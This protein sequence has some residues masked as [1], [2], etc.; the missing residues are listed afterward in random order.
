LFGVLTASGRPGTADGAV[1]INVARS[2]AH[3]GTFEAW[4]CTPELNSNH[5]V[6]GVDGRYYAGFGLLPSALVVP[7]LLVAEAVAHRT[8]RDP[9]VLAAFAISLTTVAVGALVPALVALWLLRLGLPWTPS[10]AAALVVFFG[11]VLWYD[12]VK[13][14]YSEPYFA[15]GLL[16]TACLISTTSSPSGAFGA[17]AAFGVAIASR[18]VGIVFGPLLAVYGFA[19]HDGGTRGGRLQRMCVFGLGVAPFLIAIVAS[20]YV[21]F[22]DV[23]KT[24]YHLAYPTPAILFSTPLAD[25]L[26]RLL[27]DGEVGLLWFSPWVILLPWAWV[28]AWRRYRAECLLSMAMLAEGLFFFAKYKAWHGGWAFGPRMLTPC[29]PFAAPAL[30][31]LFAGLRDR[32][33]VM[34]AAVVTLVTVAVL[35]QLGGAIYPMARYYQLATYH[36]IR[37]EPAPF[38]GSLPAAAWIDMP[39]LLGT[40]SEG[41]P[42]RGA[43]STQSALPSP[44][45]RANTMTPDQFLRSFDNPVNLV[46]P[47]LWLWKA[48]MMGLPP[49]AAVALATALLLSSLTL[50]WVAL[51]PVGS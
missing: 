8:G 16:A 30:A 14:F 32:T 23:T 41:P 48:A 24:G 26:R 34:R 29:L 35:V 50:L 46:S 21:R 31:S 37:K 19:V 20:N 27:A 4:P 36:T 2:I 39:S 9:S 40:T 15:A 18:L 3:K 38:A 45:S 10:A 25:G 1:M 33:A 6:P 5:C 42:L 22:G 51:R 49:T 17:G 12:S 11:S 43:R 7:P 28:A 13:G 47:D 44:E